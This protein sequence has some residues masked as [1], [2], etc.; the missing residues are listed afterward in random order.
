[1]S[2]VRAEMRS[3]G[4]LLGPAVTRLATQLLVALM[5]R[6]RS[7]CR[8][9]LQAIARSPAPITAGRLTAA[10]GGA[11][12]FSSGSSSGVTSRATFVRRI[13]GQI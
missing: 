12:H 10:P 1:M 9:D 5:T 8:P 2:T 13:L 3:S 7:P 4:G 11:P 6:S